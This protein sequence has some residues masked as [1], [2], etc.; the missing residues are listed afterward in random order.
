MLIGTTRAREVHLVEFLF[1][2]HQRAEIR[3]HEKQRNF[4]TLYREKKENKTRRGKKWWSKS[5]EE[6][7]PIKRHHDGEYHAVV[8]WMMMSSSWL[9]AYE[10]TVSDIRRRYFLN[11]V[12]WLHRFFLV[13]NYIYIYIYLFLFSMASRDKE[14]TR[15]RIWPAES[16]GSD[17][18]ITNL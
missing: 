9:L 6:A 10:D 17:V 8:L 11:S 15:K 2:H 13:Y 7:A 12:G 1:G 14:E 3:K 16:W 5:S 18:I 4:S